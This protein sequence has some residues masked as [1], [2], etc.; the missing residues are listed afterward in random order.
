MASCNFEKYKSA[1]EVKAH[2]R[3]NDISP[4][5]RKIAKKRNKHIDLTK[6][7]ENFDILGLSYEEISEKYDARIRE[8]DKNGNTNKRKDRVTM[9]SIVIPVP[10]DLP[11]ERYKEWYDCVMEIIIKRYDLHNLLDAKI[12]GDESH[13]YI[14]VETNQKVISRVHAHVMVIPEVQG[15]LNAKK[16]TLR[17]NMKSLNREI[18]DM[19]RAEFGCTFMTGTKKKS[20]K[21]VEQ[22]K[23]ES[24]FIEL[25]AQMESERKDLEAHQTALRVH[26][27]ALDKRDEEIQDREKKAAE[28]QG[29]AAEMCQE[30]QKREQEVTLKMQALNDA[31]K[32]CGDLKAVYKQAA[33]RADSVADGFEKSAIR[34]NLGKIL[35]EKLETVFSKMKFKDGSTAW[36]RSK[37]SVEDD[38]RTAVEAV[39]NWPTEAGL[40]EIKKDVVKKESSTGAAVR[41]LAARKSP[42]DEATLVAWA[43]GY[44]T[45]GTQMEM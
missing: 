27:A 30:A 42:I 14:N 35:N 26:K 16:L 45:D 4:E 32:E 3:H 41:D 33:M 28:L 37:E 13:E 22:L 6:A 23:Q 11:R 17:K 2:M 29:K 34:E 10:A 18:D 40:K 12:H 19:T 8:L 39:L 38:I 5:M 15:V 1:T 25:F 43:G 21:T 36:D 31:L 7:K 9:M 20:F 44:H 24:E